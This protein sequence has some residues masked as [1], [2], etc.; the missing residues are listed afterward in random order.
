MRSSYQKKDVTILLKDVTG[1]LPP[2]DT[3]EREIKIQ[4]GIHYSEMLPLEYQPTDAYLQLYEEALQSHGMM[5]AAAVKTIGDKIVSRHGESVV[6]VSLARAGTPIGI[7]VKRYLERRL[8]KKVPHYTISIIRGRGIDHNAMNYI[9]QRH[10]EKDIQFLDGWIGKGAIIREL[11]KEAAAY[12][13]LSGELAVLADPARM[14]SLYGTSEDF[15]IPS[16]CLNATVSGLFSRTILNRHIIGPDDFHGAVYF[17]ELEAFDR[18]NAF[19]DAITNN[20]DIVAPLEEENL[21]QRNGLQEAE[22]IAR[23]F[24][25][26]DI[27]FIKPGIGETTRVLLRRIPYKILVRD[28]KDDC[29]VAHIKRLCQEKQ[30]EIVEYPLKYYRACG[31]IKDLHGDV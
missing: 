16:A 12:K 20:F 21:V 9:L 26:A 27:N 30:V 6:L 24:H 28:L 25:I 4:S 31:I 3:K 2:L 18:S 17:E 23:Q 29:Y 14:T 5:T 15:L 11:K 10:S 22:E 19:L 7:L 13:D 1:M 8:K